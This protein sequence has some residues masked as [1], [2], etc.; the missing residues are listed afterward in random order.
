MNGSDYNPATIQQETIQQETIQQET[1]G[2]I[3]WLTGWSM[4]NTVFDRLRVLL[5]NFHHVSVDYSDADSPEKMLLLTETEARNIP[6]PDESVCRVR[7]SRGKPLLIGGWSLGGLL[8]LGLAC[9]KLADGLILFGATAQFTRSKEEFDRGWADVYVR[10]MI[11]ELTKD[12]QAV[13]TK[14]RRLVFTE[15]ERETDLGQSLLPIGSWTTPALITGLQILR[16]EECLSQL[17]T[18]DC[19]VLLVHGTE[20]KI[21]PYS[22]VSELMDQLPKAKLITIPASGHAPFLGREVHIA[23]ELRRWWHEQ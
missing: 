21:C 2:T 13:E 16:S 18:I 23:D 6:N 17:P 1:M 4:P 7:A 8:A 14:F 3:L 11:T 22:A 15:A 20:D 5:P 12:R 10:Q 9:K 19:P